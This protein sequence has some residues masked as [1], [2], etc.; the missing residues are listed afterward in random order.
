MTRLSRLVW[1]FPICLA[2]L[3]MLEILSPAQAADERIRGTIQSYECGDNCYLTIV[4]RS[5]VEH[6]GLC[7]APEC[8]E[9]NA[10]AEMPSDLIGQRVRVTVSEGVQYDADGNEMGTMMSFTKIRFRD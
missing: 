3:L 1:P 6:T 5:G 7:S 2:G 9:W 8:E 10:T 4:D